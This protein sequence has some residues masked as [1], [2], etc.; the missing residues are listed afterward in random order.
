MRNKAGI[1]KLGIILVVVLL[2]L[3][4]GVLIINFLFNNPIV[5]IMDNS[6]KTQME[7]YQ[8]E[9]DST[10]LALAADDASIKSGNVTAVTLGTIRKY[11]PSFKNSDYGVFE[12]VNGKVVLV[13]KK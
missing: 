5:N 3:S 2:A 13:P 8:R 9:L 10:V 4:F 1:T 6:L 12:I 7:A 11:I